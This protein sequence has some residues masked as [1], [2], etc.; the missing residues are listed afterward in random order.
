MFTIA[1]GKA[2][3]PVVG[4]VVIPST[5]TPVIKGINC[6]TYIWAQYHLGAS[7]HSD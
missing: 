1:I 2:V 7:N 6:N 3:I 5:F 4:T